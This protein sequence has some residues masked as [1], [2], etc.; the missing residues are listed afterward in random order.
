MVQKVYCDEQT[1]G[2][3]ASFRE[4]EIIDLDTNDDMAKADRLKEKDELLEE[5]SVDPNTEMYRIYP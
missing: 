4:V 3:L 1:R 5:Q 2:I